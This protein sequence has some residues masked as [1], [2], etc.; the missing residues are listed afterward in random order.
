MKRSIVPVFLNIVLV[1]VATCV[2]LPLVWLLASSFKP[3]SEIFAVPIRIL[4]PSMGLANYIRMIVDFD[5]HIA[6]FNSIAITS[7][8]VVLQ[9]LVASSCAYA[10]GTMSFKGDKLVFAFIIGTMMMPSMTMLVPRYFVVSSLKL[11][12]NY[13]GI[14]LP[15]SA[16]A[17]GVFLIRQYY[18][19]V[20]KDCFDS[21][22]IDGA[23]QPR[24]FLNIALPLT[25]PAVAA[26]A[27]YAFN[28]QWK[29]LLW[30]MLILQK[31]QLQTLSVRTQQMMRLIYD[32]DYGS[33][34]AVSVVSAGIGIIVFIAFQKQFIEGLSGS[35]KG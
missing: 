4:S 9:V 15:L 13:L 32:F 24:I 11:T 12:N 5:A 18:Y 31:P 27:I 2:T 16:S 25:K 23:S 19:A 34:M 29:D 21:A 14:I 28:T 8:S 6:L 20:P 26:F 1:L 7:G 3:D 22:V 10:F 33:V 30:P 17:V 35:I